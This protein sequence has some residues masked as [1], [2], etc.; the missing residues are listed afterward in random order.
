[1]YITFLPVGQI[2]DIWDI[3]NQNF[4]LVECGITHSLLMFI[5][6]RLSLVHARPTATPN[7]PAPKMG[8]Q[9]T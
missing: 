3:L 8:V 6:P 4:I 5:T 2:R 7:I 1:M 9:S